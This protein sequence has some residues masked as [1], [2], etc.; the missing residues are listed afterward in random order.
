MGCMSGMSE[1]SGV[2][3]WLLVGLGLVLLAVVGALVYGQLARPAALPAVMGAGSGGVTARQA[4][5]PATELAVQ[6]QEDVRLAVVSC[7]WPTVGVY[8]G[9]EVEW[10]F[11]FFSPSTQRLALV[12]VAGGVARMVRESV[13]PYTVPTFSAEA[14]RVDSDQALQ[15]WWNRGGGSLVA[16]RPDTDLAMQLRVPDDGSGRPA[17]TVVGLVVGTETVFTIVVDATSG[18]LVEQ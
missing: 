10:T 9:G 1:G 2:R 14:W 16:R 4:F 18:A 17:W 8:A 3:W 5:A 15:M 11:Q 6:W 13:S 7:R 12:T